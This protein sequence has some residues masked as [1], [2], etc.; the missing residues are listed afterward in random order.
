MG[1]GEEERG[2]LLAP[3][4]PRRPLGADHPL[5]WVRVEAAE[6]SDARRIARAG[7]AFAVC[8]RGD[9]GGACVRDRRMREEGERAIIMI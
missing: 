8:A 3:N 4:H 2:L 7:A 5:Q 9:I 6:E 1:S